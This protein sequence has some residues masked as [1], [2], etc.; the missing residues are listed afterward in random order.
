MHELSVTE[1]ILKICLAAA[2]ENGLTRIL[3]IH[4]EIGVLNDLKQEWIQQYFDRLGRGTIA[5]NAAIRVAVRPVRLFCN[6]CRKEYSI[7]LQKVRRLECPDCGGTD[8]RIDGGSGYFI[9]HME[10]T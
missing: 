1:D 7:E 6:N 4:L 5:E 9:T 2:E 3:K 8:C 10:G